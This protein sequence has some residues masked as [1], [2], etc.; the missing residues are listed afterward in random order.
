WLSAVALSD[1]PDKRRS[2]PPPRIDV[3][4]VIARRPQHWRP[5]LFDEDGGPTLLG[6]LVPNLVPALA[7]WRTGA[8]WGPVGLGGYLLDHGV[9]VVRNRR[10]RRN[11]VRTVRSVDFVCLQCLSGGRWW[12]GHRPYIRSGGATRRSFPL[13]A[14]ACLGHV[15][16]F[17]A[18]SETRSVSSGSNSPAVP[19]H[20]S[21]VAMNM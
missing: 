3:E 19:T 1:W 15:F 11:I 10:V 13:R 5:D 21:R 4:H 9:I 7:G 14:L 2:F 20:S 17:L 12:V 18:C 16:S 6:R 8:V